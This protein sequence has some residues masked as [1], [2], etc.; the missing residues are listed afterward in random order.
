MNI[1]DIATPAYVFDEE[2]L[3]GRVCKVKEFFGKSVAVCFAIKSNPFLVGVLKDVA[4]CFEVCSPGEFRICERAGVAPEKIVL[5][6]VYKNPDD[7]ERIVG[8]CGCR[9]TYTVESPSQ[10]Q[11]LESLATKYGLTLPVLLRLSAGNQFGM[12]EETVTK[13]MQ[14][15]QNSAL[16]VVGLQYYSGTQKCEDKLAK[17]TQKIAEFVGRLEAD[18]LAVGRIE[19]GSGLKVGYF[20]AEHV[21]EDGE[22]RALAEAL[23]AFDGKQITLEFG[24]FLTADCG[25]YYTQIVDVKRTDGVNYAIVDGGINHL[26]YYGQTMAMKVP[27]FEHFGSGAESVTDGWTVCGSLCTTAD[28]LVRNLPLAAPS[29]GDVIRF[30]KVGAY[31]VTEGIYLFLSRDLPNVYFKRGDKLTL[32]R[33]SVHT[34]EIN[35][36]D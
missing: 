16:N 32:V 12:D 14:R 25:S 4:D 19:Y 5:S 31:S 34:D 22:I 8:I 21:D 26:N 36:I 30:D 6:G 20:P 35:Y 28:V 17:E 27:Y 3:V 15:M 1:S 29:V 18:G 23:K 7:I 2:V 13:I 24:R 9:T 10:A 11:L 33:K